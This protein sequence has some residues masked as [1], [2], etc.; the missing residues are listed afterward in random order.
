MRKLAA[1]APPGDFEQQLYTADQARAILQIG[2]STMTRLL[3]TEIA[4]VVIGRSRR[5][6]AESLRAFIAARLQGGNGG[7][8]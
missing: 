7:A 2:R 6:P 1:K 8:R 3:A 4:S 5:I